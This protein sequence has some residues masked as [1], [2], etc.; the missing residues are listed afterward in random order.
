M[1]PPIPA[2][3]RT[4]YLGS[5]DARDIL[6]GDWDRLWRKKTGL[7]PADDLTD[8]F[9]VQ[10]GKVVEPFHIDWTVGRL[11]QERGA[12]AFLWSK[13]P[14]GDGRGPGEEDDQHFALATTAAGTP[15]GSHPDAL[16][17]FTATGEVYPLE[18]KH[19]ARWGNAEEVAQFYMPQ[20]QHHLFA[21]GLDRMLLSVIVGN[22]EPERL[23]I[24]ASPDWMA[25]Y[26][27]ACDRFWRHVTENRAPTP[28][29]H[30]AGQGPLVPSR[31]AD[32]VPINGFRR[33]D[34]SGDN[35]AQALVPE[36]LETR[37]A[38]VRHDAIKD[39]LK[40]MMQPDENELYSHALTLRRDK[41]GAIRISVRD[42]A[43]AA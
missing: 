16:L 37:R 10:L 41:R 3:D 28:R 9:P 39:E 6:S 5:S 40:A 34:I 7:L 35:R 24:G 22:A 38:A 26:V 11:N 33:R 27:A 36:F 4:T 42:D 32:S 18:A 30:D 25:H 2:L 20:L 8:V 17:R 12:G 1:S 19:T 29:F 31:I 14:E 21:W 13:G 23:W 15:I 43:R